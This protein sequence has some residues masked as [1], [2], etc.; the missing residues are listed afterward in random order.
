MDDA[1]YGALA[2]ALSIASGAYT[3]WALRTKGLGPGLRGAAL[4][5]LI[6]AAYLTQTMRMFGRIVDAVV[7]WA[8]SLVFNPTVW[9]GVVIAGISVLMFLASRFV[10]DR[11]G[12]GD[13]EAP[14]R[15]AHDP[16]PAAR[17][18]IAAAP[19]PKQRNGAAPVDDELDEIEAILRN[20]GIS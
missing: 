2:I 3:W 12:D 18:E 13:A 19:P 1:G 14:T 4:T 5:L 10:G 11:S 8:T 9:I 7:D 15:R 20:R 17:G 6:V 16:V